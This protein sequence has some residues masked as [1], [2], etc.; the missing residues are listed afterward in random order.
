MGQLQWAEP[1][2]LPQRL[3]S[4]RSEALGS[5]ALSFLLSLWLRAWALEPDSLDS[6]P[7]STTNSLPSFLFNLF[8][9]FIFERERVCEQGRGRERETESE[10]GSRL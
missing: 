7:D 5:L 6:N 9:M 1:L 4:P 10:A 8:L 3:S 2:T